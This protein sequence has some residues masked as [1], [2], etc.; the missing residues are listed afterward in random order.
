MSGL[1]HLL[2]FPK[3]EGTRILSIL[4]NAATVE[5]ATDIDCFFYQ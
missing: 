2:S 3:L 1:Q 5:D 4:L